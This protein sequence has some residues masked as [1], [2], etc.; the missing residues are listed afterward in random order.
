MIARF[1]PSLAESV[2]RTFALGAAAKLRLLFNEA[3]F[4]DFQTDTMRHT[5]VLPS[6]EA[7]YGPFERGGA[8]TGQSAMRE[9]PPQLGGRLVSQ[10]ICPPNIP[11][12]EPAA[13]AQPWRP[14]LLPIPKCEDA[15]KA[16]LA[17]IARQKPKA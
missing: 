1:V 5:F 12:A 14:G 8:S 4:A 2:A 13:D 15:F 9:R 17:G 6:F 3:G 10:R 16:R 7:Y 11:A